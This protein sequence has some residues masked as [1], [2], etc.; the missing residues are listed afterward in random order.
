MAA[1]PIHPSP[2]GPST[3]RERQSKKPSS[4]RWSDQDTSGRS[5]RAPPGK[6]VSP[7]TRKANRKTVVRA[8]VETLS[9]RVVDQ[10]ERRKYYA[11][12][13]RVFQL[14]SGRPHPCPRS[15]SF[16]SV[17]S[18][19]EHIET[20]NRTPTPPGHQCH[21]IPHITCPWRRHALRN[22][23]LGPSPKG[24]GWLVPKRFAMR[25]LS[26]RRGAGVRSPEGRTAR[27]PDVWNAW[28]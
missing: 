14:M 18:A 5:V 4:R 10:P 16:S 17:S 1:P 27:K 24:E 12:R 11:R 7:E 8:T 3:S 23:T 15:L 2:P 22:L 19:G 25:S 21:A 13:T 28:H 9:I 20:R 26:F 6:A